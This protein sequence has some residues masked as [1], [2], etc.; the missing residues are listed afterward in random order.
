[1]FQLKTYNHQLFRL[2]LS[3]NAERNWSSFRQD[4]QALRGIAVLLVLLFHAKIGG[5][6]AGYLGVD[7]FFVLSGYLITGLVHRRLVDGRFSFV[8]FYLDRAKR[9]LPA[10]YVVYALTAIAAYWVLTDSEFDRLLNTLLG[11]LTFTANIVL[12]TGTNYFADGAKFNALL[13]VWSLSIEEQFYFLLP[14]ALFLA[15]SR[16]RLALLTLGGA[17]SLALC[18]YL[19]PKS[20]VAA[21]YL[22]PTR[23]WELAFGGVLALAQMQLRT[24]RTKERVQ[25]R[26][27]FALGAVALAVLIL[28][29]AFAPG[30]MLGSLHPG[31]DAILVSAATGVLLVRRLSL[32][33]R[34]PLAWVLARLGDVSY[35][36][37]LVH[38][39]LFAFTTNAYIGQSAPIEVRVALLIVSVALAFALFYFVEEPI[40]RRPY[41][42]TRI[43][44]ALVMLT[45][46]AMVA[47]LTVSL[48]LTR[49]TAVAGLPQRSANYGLDE[50]CEFGD[51]FEALSECASS[52]SPDVLLW[53]DSFAMHLAIGLAER[54]LGDGL[55]QATKSLCGPIVGIAPY[56]PAIA[57]L[58]SWAR[59]C[60]AF[61][62]SVV[63]YIATNSDIERVVL[64]SPFAQFVEEGTVG[65]AV[66]GDGQLVERPIESRDVIKRLRATIERLQVLGKEVVIVGP[67]PATGF[68]IGLCY[69][70]KATGVP[71][72]G[73]N[74]D[75]QLS[76]D[77]ARGFR[78]PQYNLLREVAAATGARLIDLTD[79]L[80]NERTCRTEIDG[81]PLYW[82]AGHFSVD[83]SRKV[84][85]ELGVGEVILG[86]AP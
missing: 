43:R 86:S 16:Y 36:L 64:S 84:M 30:S 24:S 75:C 58:G 17:A 37:Y 8:G 59:G 27:N 73:P 14:L 32:L 25:S 72:F 70:R 4:I 77:A 66:E 82:D 53:G 60:L 38:W 74:S 31:L 46:T 21:F 63:N 2:P 13:H 55:R 28:T 51:H 69:E 19:A 76:A 52:E 33:E 48:N 11:A 10:A 20:P 29:A 23:A 47:I 15:P 3:Q 35:S 80:C 61:N 68:N 79:Y 39:P 12:W 83:G 71:V 1:M 62:E 41:R 78:R 57:Y 49:Q 85:V 26:L 34:G 67:T 40:R 50:Q 56:R 22:L 54:S 65:L 5:L 42:E 6:A 9:L 81:V 7:V 44:P 45:A 18:L